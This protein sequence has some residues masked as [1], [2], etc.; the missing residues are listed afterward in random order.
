MVDF[1]EIPAGLNVPGS[2]AELKMTQG[3]STVY[4]MPLR[5]VIFGQLGS[6]TAKALTRYEN[7]TASGAKALF[8]SGSALALSVAAFLEA[9][10]LVV[11]DAVAVE[12]ATGAAEAS[13]T[14][15]VSGTPTASGAVAITVAGTRIYA[16]VT[17]SMS[18][19][20][21]AAALQAEFDASVL[22]ATGCSATV[23]D[24]VLTITSSE[25]AAYCDDIDV[26]VSALTQDQV[27]GVTLEVASTGM[28]GG[29]GDPALS[30]AITLV[31]NVWYTDMIT[32]FND[33]ANLT[34]FKTEAERRYGAMVNIDAHVYAGLR[35]SSGTAMALTAALDCRY[36]SLV[37]AYNPR[38]SPWIVAAVS[39]ALCAQSLNDDPGRPL[40]TVVMTGLTGLGP[41]PDDQYAFAVRNTLLASGCSTF[42]VGTDGTVRIERMVTTRLTDDDGNALTR[43]DD[44]RIPKIGTR[45]R[46]EWNTYVDETYARAKYT[47]D[48]SPI[49]GTEGVVTNKT[50]KASL[51]GQAK[52]WEL[53]G[54]IENV[55]T[56]TA[57]STFETNA[58][59]PD[60]CD[61]Q[62]YIQAIGVLNVLANSIQLQS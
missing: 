7:L 43:P 47:S 26:R 6:G 62:I 9:A 60:R 1:T 56:V 54:W 42:L 41:D 15:T 18:A 58:D 30:D 3:S 21:I 29:A 20:D 55:D 8:G 34:L 45:C 33:Q 5:V 61:S 16:T 17:S 51:I 40:R 50:L 2:Y 38:W 13:T 12:E 44:I 4:A 46:Y 28:T 22:A 19:A 35:G 59:D 57:N 52:L 36:M 25:K 24:A 23:S 14:V 27:S 49:A 32:V 39:C 10:P 37:P 11:I 48:D 31:E 53:Q